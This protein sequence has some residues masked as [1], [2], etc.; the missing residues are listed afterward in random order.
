MASLLLSSVLQYIFIRVEPCLHFRAYSTVNNYTGWYVLHRFNFL[1][2]LEESSLHIQ[3]R[4]K[5]Y[6]PA[7]SKSNQVS[8][9][10]YPRRACWLFARTAYGGVWLKSVVPPIDSLSRTPITP[11]QDKMLLKTLKCSGHMVLYYM[12]ILLYIT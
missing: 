6:A 4:W 2:P 1:V 12:F 8:S 5:M 9:W 10:V 11:K 7:D 3:W